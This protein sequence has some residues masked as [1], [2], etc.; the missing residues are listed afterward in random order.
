[1]RRRVISL[2]LVSVMVLFCFVGCAEKSNKEVMEKIGKEASKDAA[3]ISMYLMSEKKVSAEQEKRMEAAVNDITEADYTVHVD[4]K[5]FTPDEYYERLE[6]D[7]GRMESVYGNGDAGK[8]KEEGTYI[9][10]NGLP[11]VHYPTLQDY[12]VNIFY[13]GGYEKYLQYKNA[14]YLKDITEELEGSFKNLKATINSKLINQ[15]YAVNDN[16]HYAVPTNRALGEYTYVLVN[17]DVLSESKYSASEI[18]SLVCH[19]CQ[20]IL[21]MVSTDKTYKALYTPLYSEVDDIELMGV[22]YFNATKGQLVAEKFS[23]LAGTYNSNW[24]IGAENSYPVMDSLFSSVDNGYYTAEEQLKILKG[25]DIKGYYGADDTDKPFAVGYVKGGLE[26]YE[27]Y[28]DDYEVIP[29]AAPKLDNETLYES[30]FGVASY[31]DNVS[32][33]MQIL[34]LLNT[35][36][37]FRNLILYGIEDENYVWVDSDV[38]DEHGNPYKVIERQEKDADKLYFMDPMKTG[39]MAIAYTAKGEDPKAKLYLFDHNDGVEV[40]YILGFSF[41]EGEIAKAIDPASL[42]ALI[43]LTEQSELI[44]K[45]I[46]EADTEDALNAALAKLKALEETDEFKAVMNPEEGSKS[47]LA[48]YTEWLIEKGLIYKEAD[49][50]DEIV[51]K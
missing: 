11:K 28:G 25:Y 5:Y 35:N 33:S 10:E 8:T 30:L 39:N 38:L 51:V 41:Y 6:K 24:K 44:Y 18:T 15:L 16:K 32:S 3:T 46:I 2:L 31:S 13:L 36:E 9:D 19:G 27:Q 20:D 21:D 26:V 48:Y 49:P 7:L 17:K 12:D 43:Y 23:I 14:N 40:D 37:E 1:M 29:V 45:E 22:K 4:I 50:D 47:V 34:T 42:D